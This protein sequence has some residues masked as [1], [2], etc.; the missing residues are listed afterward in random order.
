MAFQQLRCDTTPHPR[1]G[2]QGAAV[3]SQN[4]AWGV[5]TS[6][7]RGRAVMQSVRDLGE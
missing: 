7:G 6:R 5:R 4:S 1:S 2:P 3:W